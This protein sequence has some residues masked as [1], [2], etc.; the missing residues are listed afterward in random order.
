MRVDPIVLGEGL[1]VWAA[2]SVIRPPAISLVLHQEDETAAS[3]SE[4]AES[5]LGVFVLSSPPG[6]EVA[7]EG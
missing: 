2:K 7:A 4:V 1:T 3:V 5:G 6:K